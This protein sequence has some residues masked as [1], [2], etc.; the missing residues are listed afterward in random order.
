MWSDNSQVSIYHFYN[1]WTK[2]N[3][4]TT[5]DY[6]YA[7]CILQ[8][9]TKEPSLNLSVLFRGDSYIDRKCGQIVINPCAFTIMY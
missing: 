7:I 2:S 6:K 5:Y 8:V 4:D 9:Y 3:V 1:S